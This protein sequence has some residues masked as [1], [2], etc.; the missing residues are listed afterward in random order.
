M[1]FKETSL[2]GAFLI[3]PEPRE[4]ERG[5]FARAFCQ[6]EFANAGL[7]SQFVQINNSYSVNKGTIRGMHYQIAPFAEVKVV[8]CIQGAFYDVIIDLRRESPTY[9]KCYGVEL[10][11]RNRLALYVPE[12]FA[13]GFLTLEEKTEA[14]YLVSQFYSPE[15]ERGIRW[16]DPSFGIEWPF[17][18]ST[19]SPKDSAHPDFAD[20]S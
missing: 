11:A 12:G 15:H 13:H 18:P 7:V 20:R 5:F 4:D 2:K 1:K 6:R 8:R 3:E 19:M 16:D 9:R 10:S 14:L 17:A